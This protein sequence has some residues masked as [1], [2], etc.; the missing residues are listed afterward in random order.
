M[1]R[2]NELSTLP[3]DAMINIHDVLE[4]LNISRSTLYRSMKDGLLP[5]PKKYGK[6]MARWRLGIIREC[7]R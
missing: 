3:D 7:M 2:I 1:S 6:R 4:L 5:E